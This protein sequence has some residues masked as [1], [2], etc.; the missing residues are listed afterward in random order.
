MPAPVGRRTTIAWAVGIAVHACCLTASAQDARR[1][2]LVPRGPAG[3][4]IEAF[5][6]QADV[7]V[8]A[9]TR[10]LA[11]IT[12]NEV[13]GAL[14]VRDALAKLIAGTGLSS[15][16]TQS[17]TI[18]ITA[19][20]PPPA[21][22]VNSAHSARAREQ[23]APVGERQ[24]IVTGSR[25]VSRGYSAP[26]PTTVLTDVEIA[27]SGTQVIETILAQQPQFFGSIYNAAGNAGS[28][29]VVSFNLRGLGEQRSLTLVNGRRYTITDTNSL[30]DLN[31]IPAALVRRVEVVTGGS[32][33]IYGS[34]AV[35][36]VVNFIIRN[37][38]QGMELA[39]ATK[40]D[41]RTKTP[42]NSLTLTAGSNFAHDSGNAVVSVDYY[43]RGGI[44]RSQVPWAA[45]GLADGCVT[46]A[47]YT[48][49]GAGVPVAVPAGQS[50]TGAGGRP[51]FVAANSALIAGGRFFGVPTYGSAQSNP[52]LDAALHAAGLA[53]MS[54]F[55]F[56]FDRGSDTARP[57]LDPADR[58]N[59]NAFNYM[60]TPLRRVMLSSFVNYQFE[61]GPTG[62]LE[63]H[64]S[65]S[66]G[67]T[68]TAP[69]FVNTTMLVD[70]DNP[71]L[72]ARDQAVLR[73]LDLAESGPR[74]LRLGPRT[75]ATTP[76]DG[77]AL[78]GISRRN[79]EMAPRVDDVERKVFRVMVGVKGDLPGNMAYDGY[80][81]YARTR[82]T[83]REPNNFSLS[84]W[85]DAMLA[86][87][88]AAPVLNPFGPG[89]LSPAA[90]DAVVVATTSGTSNEQQVAAGN[91][92]GTVATMP[93]GPVDFNAGFEWRHNRIVMK[94]D[95]VTV[96]QD[97]A[98][99][100]VSLPVAGSVDVKEL[101]A[102]VRVPLL[103]DA[104]FARR[105]SLNGAGR[106]SAYSLQGLGGVWTHSAGLQWQP[107]RDV[108]VRSQL[109][110]AIRAPN[111]GELYSSQVAETPTVNDP[112][113]NRDAAVS[114]TA[115]LRALC[116][117]TGVPQG[118]VFSAGV[119]P[120]VQIA[121]VNGGNDKLGPETA[122]TI[123]FGVVYAPQR[124]ANLAFSV[125]YYRINLSGAIAPFGGNLQNLFDLCYNL[126]ANAGNAYCKAIH[127]DPST[128]A[129]M[130][131]TAY[132]DQTLAN[133]GGIRTEG[134]DIN[135]QYAFDIG[136]AG[137][138]DIGSHWSFTRDYTFTPVQNLPTLEN[139]CVGAY[140]AICGMP[141]PRW[142]GST[143]VAWHDGPLT[144]ALHH[145]FIGQVMRDT[146][147]LPLR[148]GKAQPNPADITA[149]T[150]R[151]QHYVDLS[152]ALALPGGIALHGGV[153]NVFDRQ[154]PL[155]GS[156][157]VTWG[158]GTAPGVYD[159]YGRS[160]FLAL[161]KRF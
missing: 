158:V 155:L 13:S 43:N 161:D 136:G 123:T 110:R 28:M 139:H 134:V 105:L 41:A 30:S 3:P 96:A 127:R 45:T 77:L 157:A 133:T 120:N 16:I 60:Q 135:A 156:G 56:T 138:I 71:Y 73:Q 29:G 151:A 76:G 121:A 63:L 67:Q 37:D 149:A 115:A 93:A 40:R 100:F 98:G 124:I 66:R 38:F 44:L 53:G 58:Y 68:V 90:L 112:C 101:Y 91:L 4:S 19:P 8:L 97:V 74:T 111:I 118:A 12:T 35:A 34:D 87:G 154:P 130:G 99:Q 2:F 5:A 46:P 69:A 128:G 6:R 24:V 129:L 27:Q 33:A 140:G 42:A 47:S 132:V 51:G 83:D 75:Y 102:E 116:V 117:A 22:P 148:Q 39:T 62:Y 32:S 109:Q 23:S 61:R 85:Q 104:P 65:D 153:E 131:G 126:F 55:G 106:Y 125:D 36:G 159:I 17:G 113:S 89:S 78:L 57:A 59:N 31:T 95:A 103:K 18:F 141:A 142:K 20:V 1:S 64:L 11:G 119:Q 114:R 143:R 94:P 152:F 108:T 150:I 21:A 86:A 81:S 147:L 50:C 80:Y 54:D 79:T 144:L 82:L 146:L 137:R 7:N 49:R 70:T 9:S 25:L 72:A 48:D 84:R 26:S 122:N 15:R 107:V 160:L 52:D 14:S 88:A 145:R 10:S 92:T